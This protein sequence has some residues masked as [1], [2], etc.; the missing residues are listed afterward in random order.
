M[1]RKIVLIGI[2]QALIFSTA[3]SQSWMLQL[4]VPEVEFNEINFVDA[5]TGWAFGDSSFA[6]TFITGVVLKTN[7]HGTTWIQQNFGSPDYRIFAS[8]ILN[9][10]EIFAAGRDASG[11]GNTG[12]FVKSG[13]GGIT[14]SGSTN[15]NERL[16]EVCF[17]NSLTGW[18]MG[19][20]GLLSKTI[21][22]GNT[23]SSPI[24]LTNEDIFDMK[25]FNSTTG[26]MSCGNGELY[27]TIDGGNS[28]NP[29]SSSSNED[30]TA[31][32]I[33][34]GVDAKVCG[35]GGDIINSNNSGS[36]WTSQVSGTTADL[37]DIS[38]YNSTDGF[39]AG[40]I[41]QMRNTVT[42]GNT[43]NNF[44]SNCSY[45]ITALSMINSS[46]GWFCTSN[47]DI[48]SYMN[49]TGINSTDVLQVDF[50]VVPNPGV[51][52]VEIKISH[53]LQNISEINVRDANGRIVINHLIVENDRN[54]PL[55]ISLLSRGVY[56]IE[57]RN[58]ETIAIQKL[59]KF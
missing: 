15:F 14:W 10:N 16:F 13:D 22:G 19:K 1:K 39:T 57:L 35:T 33:N 38:F 48:Y 21:D 42:G 3:Y 49:A 7:N 23:W 24:N 25:F 55:N 32:S 53:S 30:L 47:G 31:I 26:I 46:S 50:N 20:N 17:I 59:I 8:S 37:E 43:W 29:V 36:T 40:I 6:G 28:W 51:D 4:H 11:S 2:L 56:C 18:V 41:G 52:Y 27:R 44:S 58:K 45:D 34:G 12:L 5:N 54:I 9:L